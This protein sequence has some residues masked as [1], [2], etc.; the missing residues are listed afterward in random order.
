[1]CSSVTLHGTAAALN[2]ALASLQYIGAPDFHGRDVIDVAV[3]AG[4]VSAAGMFQPLPDA[5]ASAASVSS[6][7]VGVAAVNDA[8]VATARAPG[9]VHTAEDTNAIVTLV[10]LSDAD[11]DPAA[12]LFTV[13][14]SAQHG[15]VRLPLP[16]RLQVSYAGAA[17][18]NATA[19]AGPAS[20][21]TFTAPLHR[22]SSAVGFLT[23]TPAAGWHGEDVVSVTVTDPDGL[24][25]TA[26]VSVVVAPANDA[27]VAVVPVTT[28][29][30]PE[31]ATVAVPGV[32]VGDA[33]AAADT[34]ASTVFHVQLSA[35]RGRLGVAS[36]VT[37]ATRL[38]HHVDAVSGSVTLTG[39]LAA[40]NAVLATLTYTP[41]PHASGRDVISVAVAEGQRSAA[42]DVPVHS[43]SGAPALIAVAV[44]ATNDAPTLALESSS[45]TM[46]IH[47]DGTLAFVVPHT[48]TSL[49]LGGVHVDDVDVQDGA[50]QLLHVTL[51]VEH[52][53]LSLARRTLAGW[54]VDLPP[55]SFALS[56]Q[57][58]AAAWSRPDAEYTLHSMS[59]S[60][61]GDSL[62]F[63]CTLDTAAAVLAGAVTYT[64]DAGFSGTD[65]Y[66]VT[67]DDLGNTGA[68]GPLSATLATPVV[69][70]A[71]NVAPTVV[72]G[73]PV[74]GAGDTVAAVSTTVST[75]AAVV[76]VEEDTAYAFGASEGSVTVQV[77]DPDAGS[78]SLRLTAVSVAGA[79]L[80]AP[81][82]DGVKTVLTSAGVL[83]LDGDLTSLNEALS[84]LVYTPAA[85]FAGRDFVYVAAEDGAALSGGTSD[86]R[87]VS[88]ALGA[89]TAA[90]ASAASG[91]ASTASVTGASSVFPGVALVTV[92]VSAVNDG[93]A[94]ALA[95]PDA[96]ASMHVVQDSVG[97]AVL[98]AVT[99]HDV[100]AANS[101]TPLVSV[102]LAV[103][104]GALAVVDRWTYALH[105]MS[106]SPSGDSLSFSCTLDTAAAVLAGAVTYTPDAGFS[107][108]DSY[109]VTVDDLGNTGAGGPLSATLATP[110]V[111]SARNV[112]PTVVI[113][114][115]VAG[116]GDTVAAV[117]TTV[118]TSAAVVLVEEDTA[119]AFGAS[120][121]SV[122]VQVADPD[123]GSAS[124]RLTAV[125][126]AGAAL[127]APPTDGV[128]TVLTSAGVLVLDG[129][130]TSLNEAL[131]AL[132]Y[133]PAADFAGRDFVYVAAEDGAAL[134][135]G[136]SDA[137]FVSSALGALTAAAASAASG[138][139]STASVTGASSVFPGVA[140]VTVDVSA[141]NDGP[142]VALA[143]PDAAAPAVVDAVE[144]EWVALPAVTV[145][146]VDGDDQLLTANVSVTAGFG[147]VRLVSSAGLHFV[148]PP[149]TPAAAVLDTS[150]PGTPRV[151][152]F[153][154]TAARLTA[155]LATLQYRTA[156]NG[157]GAAAVTVTVHDG[158]GA[159]NR[160]AVEVFAVPVDD[161][162]EFV[163]SP[164]STTAH[165][166]PVAMVMEDVDFVFGA[167][168]SSASSSSLT[169]PSST[170]A[171]R[172][173][174]VDS[175]PTDVFTVRVWTV[176]GAGSLEL[177]PPPA[178]GAVRVLVHDGADVAF[179][180][181][182]T[183]VNAALAG[184]R[185]SPPG[186]ST[187]EQ[188]LRFATYD[189][190]AAPG[191]SAP[192][193]DQVA[194]FGTAVVAGTV[195]L[196]G[197]DAA[198]DG[199]ADAAAASTPDAVAPAVV[200]AGVILVVAADNDPPVLH[201]VPAGRWTVVE[202]EF[203]PLA[204][205]SVTDPDVSETPPGDAGTDVGVVEVTVTADH[206]EVAIDTVT[207]H[208]V[209]VLSHSVPSRV[210]APAPL[211]NP[212]GDFSFDSN[213]R[214]LEGTG[215]SLVFRAQ[216]A[217]ANA[218]LASLT[219]RTALD[220]TAP[221]AV[222]VTVSDLGN[223]GTGG[224]RAE[225]RVFAVEV[226]PVNDAPVIQAPVS[227]EVAEDVDKPLVQC[228]GVR[229]DDVDVSDGVGPGAG[230][231]LVTLAVSHG[232][233]DLADTANL[234][235]SVGDGVADAT[236]TFRG[237]PFDVNRALHVLTYVGGAHFTGAD[238]LSVAA[239]DEGWT[240]DGGVAHASLLVPLTVTEV[241]SA[242]VLALPPGARL[243]LTVAEDAS[244]ALGVTVTDVD[245]DDTPGGQVEAHVWTG[246]GATLE[247]QTVTTSA[248][249]VNQVHTVVAAV[250]LPAEASRPLQ[251]GYQPVLA[252]SFVLALDVGATERGA[253]RVAVTDPIA[254]DAVGRAGEELA[255]QGPG[256]DI[257]ESVE[258]KLRGLGL[259]ALSV[260][261]VDVEVMRHR[262]DDDPDGDG[263][264]EGLPVGSHWGYRWQ[265]TFFD[266]PADLPA[267][268]VSSFTATASWEL[269]ASALP[270]AAAA[271]PPPAITA[272]PQL[273]VT[274]TTAAAPVRGSYR[275]QL[276]GF[277]TTPI[278]HD[279]SAARM[280]QALETLPSV[281]VVDVQRTVAADLNDGHTYTLTVLDPPGN[282]HTVVPVYDAD[283][284]RGADAAVAAVEVVAGV[285]TP[286]LHVVTT[287][288][289]HVD[290]VQDV[291][292]GTAGPG[293]NGGDFVLGVD[294]GALDDGAGTPQ[295]DGSAGG[296][297][298]SDAINV[299]A[300]AQVADEV[301]NAGAGV[302]PG[303]SMQAKVT[304]LLARAAAATPP[305]PLQSQL[306]AARVDVTRTV[307]A[308]NVT[309]WRLV[310]HGLPA[311]APT[312]TVL[313][314]NTL[315]GGV[316]VTPVEAGNRLSGSFALS[317]G[318]AATAPLG[319]DATAGDVRA[320]LLQLHTVQDDVLGVGDVAVARSP[321]DLQGGR[322]WFVAFTQETP[323]V[324]V[325]LAALGAELSPEPIGAAVRASLVRRGGQH[326]ALSL[327][328]TDRIAVLADG[329]GGAAP[330]FE[331]GRLLAFQQ[332][333][334]S[335][336]L[337]GA[338]G[339]VSRALAAMT[340]TARPD[341]NGDVVVRV[342]VDDLGNT[343]SG[344]RQVTTLDVPVTVAA[345]NDPP[346]LVRPAVE[347][348]AATEDATV[349]VTG[350]GLED[351]DAGSGVMS[352]R[353]SVT[354]GQVW[355]GPEFAPRPADPSVRHVRFDGMLPQVV[356]ALSSVAYRADADYNGL[357]ELV[358]TVWDNAHGADAAS[359]ALL[360]D[361]GT[362]VVPANASVQNDRM[363][364][365]LQTLRPAG[366]P[367][368]AGNV[369]T[370]VIHINVAPA[371][372]QPYVRLAQPVQTVDE[373]LDVVL[374]GVQV[375]DVDVDE[376]DN[377]DRLMEVTLVAA[378]GTVRLT[379]VDG[380]AVATVNPV[381][382]GDNS[383][384]DAALDRDDPDVA[385]GGAAAGVGEGDGPGI[386]GTTAGTRAV[387]MR[388]TLHALNAVLGAH[389]VFRPDANFNGRATVTVA[390]YDLG[391]T[392]APYPMNH[393]L[394]QAVDVAAVN[395][396]PT[397]H[398]P[399]GGVL[400][401]LEDTQA[402][403]PALAITDD[404]TRW[405]VSLQAPPVPPAVRGHTWP[406][407]LVPYL[408]SAFPHDA[409]YGPDAP[410][411][412]EAVV[413]VSVVVDH[414][415]F[416]LTRLLPDG[417]T[418][419]AGTGHLDRAVVLSGT[420]AAVNQAL[421][422]ATYRSALNWNSLHAQQGHDVITVRADDTGLALPTT[423]EPGDD[424][425]VSLATS[426]LTHPDG[427]HGTLPTVSVRRVLVEVVPV[428]DAPVLDMPGAVY[429]GVHT[430]G[431]DLSPL[432]VGFHTFAA[433][434]D[435]DHVVA[436]QLRDVDA[437]ESGHG[438]AASG[439]DGLV[440]VTV[441][442][443]HGT[444]TL[445]G[446]DRNLASGGVR[447]HVQQL[448]TGTGFRDRLVA[449]RATVATANAAL[450][451]LVYRSVPHYYGPDVLRVHVTDL[452]NTGV[453]APG[454]TATGANSTVTAP[455]WVPTTGAATAHAP[456]NHAGDS[457][458]A[459]AADGAP[460]WPLTDSLSMPVDVAPV[461]DPPVA[462][463]PEYLLAVHEDSQLVLPAAGVL[464]AFRVED[465][466]AGG[467]AGVGSGVGP[468]S[469]GNVT[470][471]LAAG[472]GTVTLTRTDPG[473]LVQ[474]LDGN[475]TLDRT[476]TFRAPVA[477]ANQ[478]LAGA[479]Y[480]PAHNWNSL[481]RAPDTITLT[482]ADAGEFGAGPDGGLSDTK[483]TYVAV[484]PVNDAPVIF[485]P[486]ATRAYVEQEAL[487]V[488]HVETQFPYEDDPHSLTGGTVVGD[489]LP[490]IRVEDLDVAEA[491]GALTVTVTAVNGTVTLSATDGLV[492]ADDNDAAAAAGVVPPP[493]GFP[494]GAGF[495]AEDAIP[496]S[497]SFLGAGVDLG[498]RVP[499]V[500][501]TGALRYVN[502]ALAGLQ[503]VSAPD[504]YGPASVTVHV[505]DSGYTD[506]SF[507]EALSLLPVDVPAGAQSG[508]GSA[509]V[510]QGPLSDVVTIP[511]EV[512]P[513]N[514]V[515][516]WVVPPDAASLVVEEDD[517][518]VIRGVRVTDGVDV[519]D[520]FDTAGLAPFEGAGAEAAIAAAAAAAAAAALGDF[521]FVAA[522]GFG[523][524]GAGGGNR[525][526]A[527]LTH[528]YTL[529]AS[530]DVGSLTLTESESVLHFVRGRGQLDR[531]TV[532][533]GSLTDVNRALAGM[534]YTPA[535]DWTS[536]QEPRD[537]IR[538]AI[539]DNTASG[540]SPDGA[541][542]NVSTVIYVTRV[543]GVND[544]PVWT[545]PGQT[546]VMLPGCEN[547]PVPTKNVH[548]TC[549]EVVAVANID[550]WEDEPFHIAGVSVDDRDMDESFGAR[551][552]ITAATARGLVSLGSVAGLRFLRGTGV[553][554]P[555]VRFQASKAA[556]NAALAGLTYT[557]QLHY[558]GYDNVTL[559]VSDLGYTGRGG[560]QYDERV[561]PLT[562]GPVNDPVTWLLPYAGAVPAADVMEEDEL[563]LPVAFA[564]ADHPR[565]QQRY[566]VTLEADHGVVA[567]ERFDGLE[568]FNLTQEVDPPQD[569]MTQL[570]HAPR[571][572]FEGTLEDANAVLATMS[573]RSPVW[574][575]ANK[576][577]AAVTVT[578]AE[579]TAGSGRG[580]RTSD[581]RVLRVWVHPVNDAPEV[582]VGPDVVFAQ[583]DTPVYVPHVS[584]SDVDLLDDAD[585]IVRVTLSA[586]HG[587]LGFSFHTNTTS[588]FP[589]ERNALDDDL[590]GIVFDVG[591]AAGVGAAFVQFTTTMAVANTA[592]ARLR[593][594]GF[595]DWHGDD[596][597]TVAVSDLGY[598]GA[599]GP[600]TASATV[601]VTVAPV[602]DAPEVH[603][604]RLPDG[605][606]VL[607]VAEGG[608]VQLQS[609]YN[610][611]AV[612]A[613]VLT[614]PFQS[615]YEMF[616]SRGYQEAVHDETGLLATVADDPLGDIG[617]PWRL[618]M[619]RDFVPG[620][621]S[622]SPAW[623]VP[624]RGH[625]YF[626]AYQADVGVELFRTDGNG[627]SFELVKDVFPGARG[628][629]P[630][631]LTVHGDRLVF[632][633]NGVS[634][635]WR[636]LERD[637]CDGFRR[638]T[639]DITEPF[640]VGFGVTGIGR[641]AAR[642][643][644]GV[645]VDLSA[646]P[647]VAVTT[648]SGPADVP[649]IAAFW[650]VSN[651]TV[652]R[653][654]TVYDCPL[655]FHWA[656]TAEAQAYFTGTRE[657]T[658]A[659]G[660]PPPEGVP[661]QLNPNDPYRAR[662]YY[663]QCGWDGL[664]WAGAHRRRFRFSDS[665]V[666]GAYKDAGHADLAEVV[667]DDFST[668]EFA[669]ILCVSGEMEAC[670]EGTA[671]CYIRAGRETWESDGTDA[672]TVRVHDLRPGLAG[673][674]PHFVV[675]YDRV[676]AAANGTFD[677]DATLLAADDPAF[678]EAVAAGVAAPHL[679][680][681]STLA[682][683]ATVDPFGAEVWATT[684]GAPPRLVFDVN[685]GVAAANPTYLLYLPE[686]DLL[687]FSATD[688]WQGRELHATWGGIAPGDRR[689][690]HIVQDIRDGP[691]GSD[692]RF[693]TRFPGRGAVF[694]AFTDAAGHEVYLTDG[695]RAGTVL[696]KDVHPGAESS[697]PSHYVYFAAT[698]EVYF[699]ADDGKWGAELWATDGTDAGTR[700][701][702]DVVPGTRGSF[703]SMLTVFTPRPD[704]VAPAVFF[705][706]ES[707]QGFSYGYGGQELWRTDGTTSGTVEAFDTTSAHLDV[708]PTGLLPH[709]PRMAELRH[710][711]FFSASRGRLTDVRPAGGL[712]D[713]LA[714]GAVYT[715]LSDAQREA[716]D[717]L[718]QSVGG[719]GPGLRRGDTTGV[720][721]QAVAVFDLD[722]DADDEL[723]FTLSSSKGR[724]TL[725]HGDGDGDGDASLPAGM[726]WLDGTANGGTTLKFAATLHD[727]N[728]A[729]RRVSYAPLP[730]QNGED[731][732]RVAVNDTGLRGVDV[733]DVRVVTND[734]DVWIQDVN[735]A[736]TVS[737]PGAGAVPHAAEVNVETDV[738]GIA[739]DDPDVTGV[740]LQTP[741][742]VNDARLRVSVVVSGGGRVTLN[743][744]DGLRFVEGGAVK[745]TRVVVEGALDDLN[746][747]LRRLTYVC[748]SNLG[749]A[750]GGAHSVSVAVDDL[751]N[752]G[753]GDALT[754]QAVLPVEVAEDPFPPPP[755]V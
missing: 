52:G 188:V 586:R 628:S 598:T 641:A 702:R 19:A 433:T 460:T 79:A 444:V 406:A 498:V 152:A 487:E 300:V 230:V 145:H 204:G 354:H 508:R 391:N 729:L 443:D 600:L 484:V 485:V 636:Q 468:D 30:V 107:G 754:A 205:L 549:E 206:G 517:D 142:A 135:G 201:G 235:F 120:E 540:R 688:G 87:F 309:T 478:A 33:D 315:V 544:A 582:H 318:G 253:S 680:L 493:L 363:S 12:D 20:T 504:Y 417:V 195:R 365:V 208:G 697:H 514:D 176:S 580:A 141:V 568:F 746:A 264:I 103:S 158:D 424:A 155:G 749:C 113:G 272:T 496:L 712:G 310:F 595:T 574:T 435:T 71:R 340:Y 331:D 397:V 747:A 382:P 123:A 62:S 447:S 720:V 590:T 670:R 88:S 566:T 360:T 655:G 24:W 166:L 39:A 124:L 42:S 61:S 233:L 367:A 571:I 546:V 477:L 140:L 297:A 722:A 632:A 104:S 254:L 144:D 25:A 241:N 564:D 53:T 431:D 701:V 558:H 512:L 252:G 368:G 687:L 149:L 134:S 258:S 480:R 232:T 328:V 559:T 32:S 14:V 738:L 698:D 75:S 238:T 351:V 605:T 623:L 180:G 421:R 262:L 156:L 539:E 633:A 458:R 326:A 755:P 545:V 649:D 614:D 565:T 467:V 193:A 416:S 469:A 694:T 80:A 215:G 541:A 357:D 399:A 105:S 668:A 572:V 661:P 359:N 438:T 159:M 50:T 664:S 250:E 466:D 312:L 376:Y 585:G 199:A 210:R 622:S 658:G 734:V 69:V 151:L 308:A 691:A 711:L 373:D 222:T 552:E 175:T 389:V 294:F 356:A 654:G 448:V 615:G 335:V 673:A 72:I 732:I 225:T 603:V 392:G 131:S 194:A 95:D 570:E 255:G 705:F 286:E 752:T 719:S 635:N 682:H 350:L 338:V 638:S 200:S 27:P 224:P 66:V 490:G 548:R 172:L 101:V 449:F 507:S 499:A 231:F 349:L 662:V 321:P 139:A 302:Q 390:V 401:V 479:V 716:L 647:S 298:V 178:G 667:L 644:A 730:L 31:D 461:N 495:Q 489:P 219:F 192:A 383:A 289:V 609:V 618:S 494:G 343:G 177:G 23:Y 695:T 358:V 434:E 739:V 110:V 637:D 735:S 311:P 45:S 627:P 408:E 369:V 430:A 652:W 393:T 16:E 150:V 41:L 650:T 277:T 207:V 336:R 261:A 594:Q 446:G 432:V 547:G 486:N 73:V 137:R 681:Q 245:A 161:P 97:S 284:L 217:V 411:V 234:E 527:D 454:P 709:H 529:T 463:V 118:S 330:A 182:L 119:Y 693:L 462:F 412:N 607:R 362:F 620:P 165:T 525:S 307:H 4:T 491:D 500:T 689:S 380:L 342:A 296:A 690:T 751:G 445:G 456:E 415:T 136:T 727:A 535:R 659:Y 314:A 437:H 174:D 696:V 567:V 700:L 616:L 138:V 553:R 563:F 370:D 522:Q 703:P 404:D 651:S 280:K 170:M 5:G 501:F 341:W 322:S 186:N 60:P 323:L 714:A 147:D 76:L 684:P 317:V 645:T 246:H 740:R 327:P 221:D 58:A 492:F 414:G 515:P 402:T 385:A 57:L 94:V 291:V 9:V 334:P 717:R 579:V 536:E 538:L 743:S 34:A 290:A 721:A 677:A 143:D 213:V 251:E 157:N 18:G 36:D 589:T 279:A 223:T 671:P 669:G 532:A 99:V 256:R 243:P 82:T 92:D 707:V 122:T 288:A 316:V 472:H 247:V 617:E 271:P 610:D 542:H 276:G 21:L 379:E 267:L 519:V 190:V 108:T 48:A 299:R 621:A 10:A 672:G 704:T 513:V 56:N 606:N 85:D 366:A 59:T 202:D 407:D 592:L 22:A 191:S 237:R 67:V 15:A 481:R 741:L 68:G 196:L 65:S 26:D 35:T 708:A 422:D 562:V 347:P 209:H 611:R 13:T 551:L 287:A 164:T 91:V 577:Q 168:A 750:A 203:S 612:A 537:A 378:Y 464:G 441:G 324:P 377:T 44:S 220:R 455:W 117:S 744:M 398:V 37:S 337:R 257:G 64:P 597:V 400:R 736:P 550:V 418:L 274:V 361:G 587:T 240:G 313:A 129:D 259:G 436:V 242:P 420:L 169:A 86:A 70:S 212:V 409:F 509:G 648:G 293:Q 706:A 181:S 133:T 325:A 674:D 333:R 503:F 154:G 593:Y 506:A 93:P 405:G 556:A 591:S 83:V 728:V 348:V 227:V 292:V 372:D 629:H 474:L 260:S 583:E 534:V 683:A 198:A 554:D 146:D 184:L 530:V 211:T 601:N 49:S 643:T 596:V 555:I 305:G 171:V 63:S 396:P 329:S 413:N 520:S 724:L 679:E 663:S 665:H 116:A 581:T 624:W 387:V 686:A 584:V 43:P 187:Q 423:N 270:A 626:T 608:R 268:T 725:G 526:V 634:T 505:T 218:A 371:N 502:D 306:A 339:D 51:R 28:L 1:M 575:S 130:L 78:A 228:H 353:L 352:L 523:F 410:T 465:V 726:T 675:S 599:G 676:V 344:G 115:P 692:P 429:D 521:A 132:V 249:H 426:T 630:A 269:Q 38:E 77:A 7:A 395:D 112:A 160:T 273:N 96:A 442:A 518:L 163:F 450:N 11:A 475:G 98:P 531:A 713:G 236:M 569:A 265:V 471:T 488:V 346:V 226:V 167:D 355:M 742:G 588:V 745:A 639:V 642:G 301:A 439:P 476:V 640:A 557:S 197:V 153:R 303:D 653:P 678:R 473:P 121:G 126:V 127:A 364:E 125:S 497:A 543:A 275:L 244:L 47:D 278:A 332:P 388:G 561:I 283:T 295:S 84:A 304:T 394:V 718:Q 511:L 646:T 384:P 524:V 374:Q 89:L 560:P 573:Y 631:W 660:A 604:F 3:Q 731:V 81:P 214:P 6:L 179:Q 685:P 381:E 440:E 533:V 459:T 715:G 285:G 699:Q 386:R 29:M 185:Y 428:N 723:L 282:L 528:N 452:G 320:A 733:R 54:L 319:V 281:G 266:A 263:T 375:E 162:A 239:N 625:L 102:R 345:A 106:T 90:A 619:V 109:V 666:T 510:G 482:V 8:P 74:A 602:N 128:K 737:V 111:V 55:A 189:P 748:A 656:S 576:D 17:A 46:A 483:T 173:V 229:V 457:L 114:V 248:T 427:V 710:T 403:V 183:A 453:L 470:V 451:T 753:F 657:G 516:V 578:V 613:P 40:L 148:A 216:L 419:L 425:R 100:D 2:E